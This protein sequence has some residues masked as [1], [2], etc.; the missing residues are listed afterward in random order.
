MGSGRGRLPSM[1]D[2]SEWHS[3]AARTLTSTS[4]G[5]GGASSKSSIVSGRDSAY[6]PGTPSW[7]NT[8]ALIFMGSSI[9]QAGRVGL[10]R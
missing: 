1:T 2:R 10:L 3:P 7:R 4:P 5:P 8:A 6:G 9:G